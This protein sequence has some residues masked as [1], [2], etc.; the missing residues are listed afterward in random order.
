MS[1]KHAQANSRA[2]DHINA[3]TMMMK[4][5]TMPIAFSGCLSTSKNHPVKRCSGANNCRAVVEKRMRTVQMEVK[6]VEGT[7]KE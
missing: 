4:A 3:P 6:S 2:A 5:E 7:K 1:A